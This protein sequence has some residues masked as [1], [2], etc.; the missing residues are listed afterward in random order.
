MY[1]YTLRCIKTYMGMKKELSS[2]N[3]LLVYLDVSFLDE[4][5]HCP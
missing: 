4:V 1:T 2:E 3:F 5:K